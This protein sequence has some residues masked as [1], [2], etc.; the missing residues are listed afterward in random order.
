MIDKLIEI[1]N[2]KVI[3][4]KITIENGSVII[5]NEDSDS[6]DISKMSISS[7]PD[8][9]I[10]FT[11]DFDKLKQL[12]AY[13]HAGN[14]E[15]NKSCDFV[16]ITKVKE[17]TTEDDMKCYTADIVVGELKSK[18]ITSKGN[19]QINNS[20]IFIKYLNCLLEH[21]YNIKIKPRY[22]RRIITSDSV[23]NRIGS[24]NKEQLKLIPTGPMRNKECTISY[25]A[26]VS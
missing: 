23:K 18:R 4:E 7:V 2:P 21:H 17:D 1:I 11:L 13:L 19:K 9:S 16:I 15:I 5:I 22:I 25:R 14:D 24:T 26:L 12:S 8:E 20:I 10:G 3:F 6:S